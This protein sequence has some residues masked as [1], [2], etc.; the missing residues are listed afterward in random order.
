MQQACTP[1]TESSSPSTTQSEDRF[2][3]GWRR[4]TR[5]EFLEAISAAVLDTVQ[6]HESEQA[7]KSRDTR[8]DPAEPPL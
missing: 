7:A 6:R 4:L 3:V 2:S 5:E 1:L 8:P